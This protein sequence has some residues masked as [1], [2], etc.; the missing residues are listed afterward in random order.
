MSK[1]KIIKLLWTGNK[2]KIKGINIIKLDKNLLYLLKN[3]K[4]T[5]KLKL[6]KKFQFQKHILIIW[7]NFK[8]YPTQK[9][10]KKAFSNIN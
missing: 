4:L 6:H 7:H 8:S 2:Y 5:K 3:A 1:N 9:N 10:P